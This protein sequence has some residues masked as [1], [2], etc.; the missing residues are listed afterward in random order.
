MRNL[1]ASFTTWRAHGS[2]DL[3]TREHP[4][5]IS[6]G[7][8]S[9]TIRNHSRM[10]MMGPCHFGKDEHWSC[11]D[12][13]PN[14]NPVHHRLSVRDHNQCIA[15]LPS[16]FIT[17]G[18]ERFQERPSTILRLKLCNSKVVFLVQTMTNGTAR[19]RAKSPRTA[20][21]GC[22][23]FTCIIH[24]ERVLVICANHPRT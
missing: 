17:K 5:E 7:S 4:K 1:P 15:R 21:V 11:S 13:H 10:L 19:A 12:L 9:G 6:F 8:S 3:P 23:P 16:K 22:Q 2:W 14:E 18:V 20:L 24:W